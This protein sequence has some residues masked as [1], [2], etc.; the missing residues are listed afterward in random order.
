MAKSKKIPAFNDS[1]DINK[2]WIVFKK[3]IWIYLISIVLTVVGAK[4]YIR[5]TIPIYETSSVIQINNEER[6]TQLLDIESTYGQ[7]SLTNLI[8]LIRS[9]EFLKRSLQQLNLYTN[10]FGE[11]HFVTSELYKRS[12]FFVELENVQAPIQNKQI[13]VEYSSE[14]N[15]VTISYNIDKNKTYSVDI[16]KN[17]WT[18]INGCKI[19]VNIISPESFMD[20]N[21]KYYFINYDEATALSTQFAQL[22]V[23]ILSSD[24]NTIQIKYTSTNAQK[25]SEIVNTIS[26]NFLAYNV[27]KKQ[28][29]AEKILKFINEQLEI[30]YAQLT[31]SE[32]K[33]EQFKKDNKITGN[34]L[35][36]DQESLNNTQDIEKYQSQIQTL[37][38]V[39][40][41]IEI[42]EN[43]DIMS[44]I[45]AISGTSSESMILNFLN[46]IQQL[47]KQKEQLLM[48]L[49]PDNHKIKVIDQ[50][51][52]EQKKYLAN[53]INIT[54]S[55]LQ[56]EVNSL[57]QLTS[58]PGYSFNE[59]E[60]AKLKRIYDVHQKFYNQ[61][62]E[63]RAEYL[64]SKAGYITNNLILQ[65][66]TIP[67]NPI[68]PIH[69]YVSFV[70]AVGCLFFI[71]MITI[72]SYMLF[73]S[74]ISIDDISKYTS[75]PISGV[76]PITL[77]SDKIHRF[78]VE[79]KPDSVITESFRTL[80]SN[81]EFLLPSKEKNKIIA[82]T[83]TISGEGKTFIAINLGG[84]FALSGKK[85]ILLD[86][87]LRKPKVHLS[88][89]AQNN[90][91]MST[92]LIG[93][94]SYKDCIIKTDFE[95]FDIIPSGP[96]PPNPTELANSKEFDTLLEELKTEYDII[97]IDTPPIGIVSDA[98][99]SFQR[100][101]LPIY[102]SRANYSK[103]M[104]INNINY[105]Y[106]QSSIHNLSVILNGVSIV[107]SKY[108]YGYSNSKYGYSGYGYGY[109]F[110]YGYYSYDKTS[111]KKQ[112]F[113]DRFRRKKHNEHRH[114][115]NS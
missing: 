1:F 101:D 49:T 100:A 99:F 112:N 82:V 35:E 19:Y 91:G 110:G 52:E 33:L 9:S 96:K 46:G 70:C 17:E 113:L 107:S 13:Y 84:V 65:K 15:K 67:T 29:R 21:T 24:A 92:I 32:Q 66:S 50:Q 53:I 78:V 37:K 76:I 97:I 34:I 75:A 57:K 10:Y 11:G 102:V 27:E 68:S 54:N 23:N 40:K 105:L 71:F 106:E 74:I 94:N 98:I 42:G 7:S 12:P 89:N 4:L 55:K 64:I 8:E 73:N 2:F 87:D 90:I 48:T 81:L 79:N 31:D 85:V 39:N 103:R 51:I 115:H 104:F 95:T 6:E 59:T 18:E 38:K 72:I 83:S 20:R 114:H 61:L 108:G 45:S 3:N 80:R 30:V 14:T 62:V 69:S 25:A 16:N 26:E 88:F 44:A 41:Q 5:Y 43:F 63:K 111:T 28:E 60:L 77:S 47:Q 58:K 93:K 22:D 86:L 56:N 109:G 36:N